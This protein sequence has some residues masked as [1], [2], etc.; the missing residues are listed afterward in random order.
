MASC[1]LGHLPQE[2][3][4]QAFRS[5]EQK[6]AAPMSLGFKVLWAEKGGEFTVW[7]SGNES[8]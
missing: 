4:I 3:C 8:D 6:A 1:L 5:S 7:L 2:G